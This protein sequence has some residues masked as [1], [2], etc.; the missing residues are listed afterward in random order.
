M[1]IEK[2]TYILNKERDKYLIDILCSLYPSLTEC[3]LDGTVTFR[4]DD[5]IIHSRACPGLSV[6]KKNVLEKVNEVVALQIYRA[7]NYSI[8][9]SDLESVITVMLK[10]NP[11]SLLKIWNEYM[12]SPNRFKTIKIVGSKYL[13]K[14][15][16]EGVTEELMNKVYLTV[17]DKRDILPC[18]LCSVCNGSCK[19]YDGHVWERIPLGEP[20]DMKEIEEEITNEKEIEEEFSEIE[21]PFESLNLSRFFRRG[22][23]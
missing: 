14:L 17:E 19:K 9:L 18:E 12:R 3:I 2:P 4:G 8:P 22:K 13:E 11:Y 6:K 7:T 20:V 1:K 16:K 15:K 21:L 5:L 10:N 23:K